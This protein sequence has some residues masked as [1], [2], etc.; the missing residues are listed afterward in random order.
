MVNRYEIRD[1]AD[2]LLAF[3]EQ[4]RMK[5]EEEVTF[6]SD[7]SKTCPVFSFE[8][9]QGLDVR[10]EH[11]VFD[12]HGRP[13]GWFDVAPPPWPSPSTRRRAANYSRRH[14]SE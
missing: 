14:S 9:R 13:L 11:D 3:A 1:D 12:E 6:F 7:D 10:A 2:R 4:K 8:A 5:F